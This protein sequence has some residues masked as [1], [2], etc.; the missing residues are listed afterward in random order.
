[1]I[2]RC[3]VVEFQVP[4][5]VLQ[6]DGHLVGILRA[7]PLRGSPRRDIAVRNEI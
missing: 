3:L 5:L 6:N 4:E 7:Q 1:L 2:A